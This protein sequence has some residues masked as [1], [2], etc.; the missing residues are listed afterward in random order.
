VRIGACQ[1]SLAVLRHN[2]NANGWRPAASTRPNCSPLASTGGIERYA[3]LGQD[4]I[5]YQVLGEGPPDLVMT[6]AEAIDV[7]WEDPGVALFLRS[8][9]S[10]FRLIL[11]DR[12]GTGA[13]DPPPSDPLPPWESH[14]EELAVVLD[15]VGSERAAILAEIDTSP[16]AIFFAAT[17]PG[18][19]SA[20]IL[21]HASAKYVA[22]DDYPIGI[23]RECPAELV[24]SAFAVGGRSCCAPAP[25]RR[26]PPGHCCAPC[27]R[28]TCAR[29]CR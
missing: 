14:A 6:G 10:V 16:A 15:A 24:T 19:T 3:W 4:R 7:A 17:R 1:P 22:S 20:L 9:A 25:A 8:L 28:S 12:R 13:S 23:P 29:C 2:E 26:P 27:W 21:V 18:R 11:F 5:A